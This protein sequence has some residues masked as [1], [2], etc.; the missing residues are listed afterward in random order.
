MKFSIEK[1]IISTLSVFILFI[2]SS[3]LLHSI[4]QSGLDHTDAALE[5]EKTIPFPRKNANISYITASDVDKGLKIKGL[6]LG[7]IIT[8]SVTGPSAAD[9]P[10]NKT[11]RRKIVIT[12][13]PFKPA[14]FPGAAFV[15]E[16]VVGNRTVPPPP[17]L[18]PRVSKAKGPMA[19]LHTL[20]SVACI[21]VQS[22][23]SSLS[24]MLDHLAA[25]CE[26]AEG[27]LI[28]VSFRPDSDG[29]ASIRRDEDGRLRG[30]TTTT[31]TTTTSKSATA[32][33]TATAATFDASL[34]W[35]DQPR[36]DDIMFRNSFVDYGPVTK[37]VGG[38]EHLFQCAKLV[39]G[40]PVGVADS[41]AAY[42]IPGVEHRG[43]KCPRRED[44]VAEVAEDAVVV[45]V[46]E[47]D[48]Y[49]EAMVQ[50][51]G[52]CVRTGMSAA[53]AGDGTADRWTQALLGEPAD[54]GK[55]I[56]RVPL[57]NY[58]A[59]RGGVVCYERA[60]EWAGFAFAASSSAYA[61]KASV[62][63]AFV[64]KEVVRPPFRQRQS[65]VTSDYL[66]KDVCFM[67]PDMWVGAML[68]HH[69]IWPGGATH[70]AVSP[71]PDAQSYVRI[72]G[73]AEADLT[74]LTRLHTDLAC[75][76]R[77]VDDLVRM[78]EHKLRGTSN[79]TL[80]AS[81]QHYASAVG[82][83]HPLMR[84]KLVDSMLRFEDQLTLRL[85]EKHSVLFMFLKEENNTI[86]DTLRKE[87]ILMPE[88]EQGFTSAQGLAGIDVDAI[89]TGANTNRVR[90]RGEDSR[91]EDMDAL[92]S[93]P[94]SDVVLV[95]TAVDDDDDDDGE[96]K[97]KK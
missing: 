62:G 40:L 51:L 73:L 64:L 15:G 32:T 13:T 16:A 48:S 34:Q 93:Q 57:G 74:N 88:A 65:W 67:H 22:R 24:R 7:D 46:D 25:L 29:A 72:G 82:G 12:R 44:V 66:K 30:I 19:M 5:A 75:W 20:V 70:L 35:L 53:A 81:L 76:F 90:V 87:V 36:F 38:V 45:V 94:A 41:F 54:Q 4:S 77:I 43:S 85:V 28:V 52:Q 9:Q 58:P 78:R 39:H 61:L 23:I 84:Q 42:K 1:C 91:S 31:T 56:A 71:P 27:C 50:R 92:A 2:L 17:R 47:D 69:G 59:H 79:V 33:A 55:I 26:V 14:S 11:S 60:R 97:K 80:V 49:T 3:V 8:E 86:W 89:V 96:K 37:L 63:M 10:H 83:R 18:T 21:P 68:A 95:P 6:N